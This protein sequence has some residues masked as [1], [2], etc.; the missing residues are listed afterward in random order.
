MVVD[1]Y[2]EKGSK[3]KEESEDEPDIDQFDVG[4]GG[5]LTGY[6]LEIHDIQVMR[7]YIMIDMT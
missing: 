4:S 7:R 1:D 6:S 3:R 5:D 2:H